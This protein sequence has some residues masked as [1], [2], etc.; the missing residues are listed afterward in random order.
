MNLKQI[1]L[2]DLSLGCEPLDAIR[3]LFQEV[4]LQRQLIMNKAVQVPSKPI[5]KSPV[6]SVEL[7]V[8]E[9]VESGVMSLSTGKFTK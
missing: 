6:P 8:L 5:A 2:F 7:K 3:T 4:S 9:K 1:N